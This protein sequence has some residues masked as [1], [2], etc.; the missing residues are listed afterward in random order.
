MLAGTQAAGHGTPAARTV[1]NE[2]DGFR[3]VTNLDAEP[4]YLAVYGIQH[5]MTCARSRITGPPLGG[6]AE[7]AVHDQAIVLHGLLDLDALTLDEVAVLATA[8]ARPGHT[9]MC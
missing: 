6:A 3:A 4:Y 1:V 8:N 9:E 7:V 5:G 2:F